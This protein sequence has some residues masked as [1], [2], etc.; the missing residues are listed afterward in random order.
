MTAESRATNLALTSI[1]RALF[2]LREATTT[3][4]EMRTWTPR[5]RYNSPARLKSLVLIAS[6]RASTLRHSTQSMRPLG[7]QAMLV[8]M[9][10]PAV[11][12]LVVALAAESR[13]TNLLAPTSTAMEM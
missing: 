8:V 13:T 11:V 10:V 5:G 6:L 1:F 9:A 4:M 12:E 3:A 2:L 7:L